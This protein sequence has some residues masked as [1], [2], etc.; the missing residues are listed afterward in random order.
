MTAKELREKFIKFFE[1]RGHTRIPSSS[2][3]PEKDESVKQETLF[4]TAGMQPLITYLLGK[5][6]P[7]GN[8]LVDVQKCIRTKDIDEVGD[9]RHLTFFEM[10]GNW[11][12]NDG[13][14]KEDAIRWSFEFLTDE[15]EGLGLTPERLYVTVFKGDDAIPRDDKAIEVWKKVFDKAGIKAEVAGED[16]IIKD[17]IRIIPLG[18]D[19]NFWIAGSEG[20]CGPDTEMFYDVNPDAEEMTGKFSDLVGSSR[21]I[22]IWNDVFMEYNRVL[23]PNGQQ[24]IQAPQHI[25]LVYMIDYFFETLSYKDIDTGMGLERMLAV[26]EKKKNVYDTELFEP[27]LNIIEKQSGKKYE[28]N[29]QAFRII[30]D[31]MK[32]AIMILGDKNWVKPS[33]IGQGYVLRRLIRRA[34]V[35]ANQLGIK[36]GEELFATPFV[37]AVTD[38]Y[39]DTY[40]EMKSDAVVNRIHLELNNEYTKFALTLKNGLKEL[41]RLYNKKSGGGM[42]INGDDLFSLYTTYGFPIEMSIEEIDRLRK[43]EGLAPFSDEEDFKEIVIDI[44]FRRLKEHQE[45]SR[46]ASAGQF[47]GG[48]ADAGVETTRLH[49]AAHLMLAALRQVLGDHVQQKGSNITAERL[50][51]DFSHPQKVTSEE[52]KKVEDIVNNEISKKTPVQMEEMTVDEAKTAGATGVFEHKYGDKVKVYT[53]GN[54]SKEICG[55]PHVDNT[56]ELGHFKIIKEEASSAGIRRIKAVLEH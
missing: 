13:Y 16:E 1:E 49:T 46:T 25:D 8:R 15:K 42:E 44:F 6:H 12:L 37:R 11:S 41:K 23:T 52:I 10:L 45:L 34:V 4:I 36:I 3:I 51:F 9:D 31:H 29:E 2:L 21:I 38:M 48:L 19:D 28:D 7:A 5:K 50:R 33:N 53:I 39:K 30:A 20:P 24:K 55:G 43:N 17:D 27:L 56:G 40:I 47:K 54:F 22:E 26:L 18:K 35:Y 14:S 32:A